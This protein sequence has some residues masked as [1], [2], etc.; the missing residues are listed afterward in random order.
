MRMS[1][2][3]ST[4]LERLA[5]PDGLTPGSALCPASPQVK[6]QTRGLTR[7]TKPQI[8]YSRQRLAHQCALVDRDI[9]RLGEMAVLGDDVADFEGNLC[10]PATCKRLSAVFGKEERTT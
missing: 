4:A 3:L 5:I 6:Q 8:S 10:G 7:S 9:D 2:S 1:A